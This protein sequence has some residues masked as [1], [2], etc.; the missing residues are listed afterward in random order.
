MLV[1]DAGP[2]PPFQAAPAFLEMPSAEQHIAQ[3]EVGLGITIVQSYCRAITP[4]R[5]IFPFQ[6]RQQH[7]QIRPS[8]RRI[9]RQA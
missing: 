1:Q 9:R 2:P 7:S 3:I 6:A 8:G 5:L 4:L